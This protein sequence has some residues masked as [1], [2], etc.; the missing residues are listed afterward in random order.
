MR[1]AALGAGRASIGGVSEQG[2]VLQDVTDLPDGLPLRGSAGADWRAIDPRL[3]RVRR[4]V[5]SVWL[6]PLV[7]GLTVPAVLVSPWF[8][9]GAV[10]VLALWI[11][12]V[13]F[14][15]R[16]VSAISFAE[17]EDELAIRKGR[18][19]RSL[20]TIPYGRIQYVDVSAGP[21]MR[22]SGL[23]SIEVHTA[24]PVSAGDLPGLPEVQAQQLRQRLT[25]LGESRRA[26]L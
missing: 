3:A 6:L 1:C 20:V 5:A 19:F 16:Q 8:A 14:I 23:A 24:N 10:L 2:A 7:L 26:G 4:L 15:G 22:Q 25:A 21:L 12:S 13:W 11:W 18:L 17:L 9:I